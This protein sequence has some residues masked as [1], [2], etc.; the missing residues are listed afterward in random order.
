VRV[1]HPPRVFCER[2]LVVTMMQGYR[3][4][5]RKNPQ[6]QTTVESHPSKNEGWGTLILFSILVLHYLSAL[7]HKL[8]PLERGHLLQRIAIHRDDVGPL[9]RFDCAHLV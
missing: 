1:P 7:H 5:Y 9:A 2:G 8:N 4:R 6:Q 3:R